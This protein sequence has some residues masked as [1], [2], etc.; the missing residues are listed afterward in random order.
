MGPGLDLNSLSTTANIVAWWRFGDGVLDYKRNDY[1]TAGCLGD[2]NNATLGSDVL[3]GKG[4]FS[5]PSYW[6]VASGHSVVE[7]GKGKF[8]GTGTYGHITKSGILNFAPDFF[9]QLTASGSTG[10]GFKTYFIAQDTDFI[11]YQ[12]NSDGSY[13]SKITIDNVVVRPVNGIPGIMKNMTP[14][15]FI[16]DAP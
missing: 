2:E 1:H 9:P 16:I 11:L 8:L 4:D 10:T 6:T 13:S 12:S 15:D 3:G 5:D 14:E 7:D